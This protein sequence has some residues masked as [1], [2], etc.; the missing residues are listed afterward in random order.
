MRER[1]K[2]TKER[3]GIIHKQPTNTESHAV[4]A[5]ARLLRLLDWAVVMLSEAE[6][7]AM[8]DACWLS[9]VWVWF[10]TVPIVLYTAV[11]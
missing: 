3:K 7:V 2:P 4:S 6:M 10:C 8:F 11:I 1:E 9:E 5:A